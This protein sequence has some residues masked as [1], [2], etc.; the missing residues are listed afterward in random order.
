MTARSVE[1]ELALLVRWAEEFDRLGPD[2]P[3]RLALRRAC[4]VADQAG[5][6]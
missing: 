6:T 5:E 4:A 3:A 2:E 1:K